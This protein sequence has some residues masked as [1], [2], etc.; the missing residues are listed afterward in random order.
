MLRA[1]LFRVIRR[2]G[3]LGGLLFGATLGLAGALAYQAASAAASH[4][5]AAEASLAHHA[6]IAAWR[7]S[8]EG[9]SWVGYGMT[10]AGELLL[11]EVGQHET[12]PGPGLLRRLLAEKDCDC[13][14]AGFSR[15]VFRVSNESNAKLVWLAEAIPWLFENH[16][17]WMSEAPPGYR[18]SLPLLYLV[19]AVAIVILYFP[20]RWFAELKARRSDKW[21]SYL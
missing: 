11:H 1:A 6:T 5:A 9:R 3:L 14:S 17:M 15:T 16:P 18:W 2:P 7:F 19:F 10:Q 20:C 13:M 21:L 12:L 8:R 4:R